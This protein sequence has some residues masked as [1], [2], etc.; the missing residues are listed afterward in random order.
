M[1]GIPIYIA[2]GKPSKMNFILKQSATCTV[3]KTVSSNCE[4]LKEKSFV[5]EINKKKLQLWNAYIQAKGLKEYNARSVNINRHDHIF[6]F[7]S[8]S[9]LDFFT[10]FNGMECPLKRHGFN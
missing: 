8:T 9:Y 4:R 2:L 3:N 7:P 5:F 6:G 10:W 1:T